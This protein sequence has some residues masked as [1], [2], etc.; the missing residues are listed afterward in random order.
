[1]SEGEVEV[2]QPQYDV[3]P[4]EV[5]AEVGSVKLFSTLHPPQ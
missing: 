5:L 4:K 1:M 3:L 2:A